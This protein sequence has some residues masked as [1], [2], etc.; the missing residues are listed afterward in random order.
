[1]TLYLK[2]LQK[3]DRSKLKLLNSLKKLELSNLSFGISNVPLVPHWK[4]I[5]HAKTIHEGSVA[6]ACLTG[7]LE[8]L[9]QVYF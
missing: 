4:A 1:M 2:G 8:K 7:H 5:R 3:W 9:N 6:A